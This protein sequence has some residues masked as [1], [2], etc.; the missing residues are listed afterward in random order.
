MYLTAS[1]PDILFATSLCARFQCDPRETHVT[2]IKRIFR[3]L[4]G[5]DNLCLWYHRFS[6]F[7]LVGYTDADYAGYLVDRKSTSV[8]AQFI[9]PYLVSWGSRK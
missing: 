9:G 1:C 3:Y 2:I 4:K 5:S 8:M 7:S 6:T